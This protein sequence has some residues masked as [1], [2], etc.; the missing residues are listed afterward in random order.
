MN[1]LHAHTQKDDNFDFTVSVITY[2]VLPFLWWPQ[3]PTAQEVVTK[4]MCLF[5][6]REDQDQW[7]EAYK[8]SQKDK[9]W[10][11]LIHTDLGGI[12][13]A[14]KCYEEQ[15]R[16]LGLFNLQEVQLKPYHSLYWPDMRL[17]W[18]RDW[19]FPPAVSAQHPATEQASRQAESVVRTLRKPP[20]FGYTHLR[21]VYIQV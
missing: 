19:T 3:T 6:P 21:V 15:L 5:Q 17:W 20:T 4:V 11:S 8:S 16:E 9:I 1:E 10:C 14:Y 2:F 18:G 13:Y 12:S 7:A